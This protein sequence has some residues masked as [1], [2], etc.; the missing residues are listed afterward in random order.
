MNC[1]FGISTIVL[2]SLAKSL[3]R[4][5]GSRAFIGIRETRDRLSV[6]AATRAFSE[7]KGIPLCIPILRNRHFWLLDVVG[8]QFA[9]CHLGF[10]A[11]ILYGS[12]GLSASLVVGTC[13]DTVPFHSFSLCWVNSN[14]GSVPQH[15][16]QKLCPDS[17]EDL[18]R[19]F[20]LRALR[21]DLLGG[22]LM[23]RVYEVHQNM[24]LQALLKSHHPMPTP[25][26]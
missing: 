13:C 7:K 20:P 24:P 2:T 19:R 22:T 3:T 15:F 17:W 23:L 9:S 6:F 1:H 16:D 18:A 12:G 21:L 8:W 10:M 26:S 25:K 4:W 11:P 14:W 5:H